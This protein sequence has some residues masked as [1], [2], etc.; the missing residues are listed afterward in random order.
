MSPRGFLT[1]RHSAETPALL[2]R[3]GFFDAAT[4]CGNSPPRMSPRGFLTRRHSAETP[5]ARAVRLN[6]P[7][8]RAIKPHQAAAR[9]PGHRFPWSRTVDVGRLLPEEFEIVRPHVC[10]DVL[11]SVARLCAMCWSLRRDCAP[12]AGVCGGGRK[13]SVRNEIS[14]RAARIVLSG[15]NF[16]VPSLLRSN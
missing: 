3:L 7:R 8:L 15:L 6:F 5:L 4:F 9:A 11:E 13:S 10:H 2:T 16:F 1:R 14:Q 12:C